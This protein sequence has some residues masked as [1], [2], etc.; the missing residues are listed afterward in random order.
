MI[1]NPVHRISVLVLARNEAENLESLL[2]EVSRVLSAAGHDYDITVVDAASR[3]GTE[4]VARR[5]G[6]SVIQQSAPGYANA[7][8]QGIAACAGD[9]ILTIDADMSHRPSFILDLLD[10]RDD[11][12][13]LI[14]SRYVAGGSADMPASRIVL[15]RVLNVLFGRLL[16]IDVRDMSSGFRL[17]DRRIAQSLD[18]RG[19]HFDVL[20]ELVALALEA[21][22]RVVEV[23][24]H[25]HPRDAGVSKARVIAFGPSYVRTLGR[26]I[27]ARWSSGRNRRGRDS[28]EVRGPLM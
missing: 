6:A 19:E 5:H 16:G 28:S 2:P 1:E 24:F 25:Y 11:A 15:S 8:R 3:D 26:C 23:P 12:E 7:L 9:A 22:H 4:A 13:I 21:G 17:Y 27:V 18:A 10:R 20:P 14:A